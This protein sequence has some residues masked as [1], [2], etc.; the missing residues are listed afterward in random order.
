[1]QHI[2]KIIQTKKKK[3][4]WTDNRTVCQLVRNVVRQCDIEIMIYEE[5]TFDVILSEFKS[6]E[7]S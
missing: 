4:Q 3:V 7:N 2:L 6:L 5:I 1:M